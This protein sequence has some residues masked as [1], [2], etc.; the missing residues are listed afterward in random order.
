[1]NL[2]SNDYAQFGM[3]EMAF[4]YPH[5]LQVMQRVGPCVVGHVTVSMSLCCWSCYNEYELVLLV[6]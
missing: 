5:M 2:V 6:M 4:P 3:F 1:M